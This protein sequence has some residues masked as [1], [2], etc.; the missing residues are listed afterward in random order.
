MGNLQKGIHQNLLL[1][2]RILMK[3]TVTLMENAN[4]H[5]MQKLETGMPST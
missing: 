3:A 4:P 2:R 1:M 5:S